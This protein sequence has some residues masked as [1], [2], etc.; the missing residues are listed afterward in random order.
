M[1]T[2]PS[3]LPQAKAPRAYLALV[4][5]TPC[6]PILV[7]PGGGILFLTCSVMQ[8]CDHSA[9]AWCRISDHGGG[10]ASLGQEERASRPPSPAATLCLCM[11]AVEAGST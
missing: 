4:P 6:T 7:P 11:V 5:T 8:L 9:V 10:G 3:C 2:W 1:P